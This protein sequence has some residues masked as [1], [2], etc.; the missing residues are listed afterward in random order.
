MPILPIVTYDDDVLRTKTKPVKKNSEELQNL[1]DDMFETMYNA[2]GV[3]LAA[4]QVGQL[5][6]VFVADADPMIDDADQSAKK[7]G[8]LTMINPEIAETSEAEVEMEEGCLSIPG[9][10]AAVKRPEKIKVRYL[11]RDFNQ[12]ELDLDGWLSR[13]VQHEKD[14]LD[15]VLFLEYLSYFK[16]KML[17]SK[18]NEIEKGEKETDYPLVPK[19]E[20]SAQQ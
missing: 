10:N 6:R 12:Q 18:L 4:P 11:D 16:Q 19:K 2:D 7:Y 15:G 5:V 1:I 3:G 17:S 20:K 8:P 9:V 13:V 14:H